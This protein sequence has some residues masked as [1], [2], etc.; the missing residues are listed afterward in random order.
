[1]FGAK[2]SYIPRVLRLLGVLLLVCGTGASLLHMMVAGLLGTRPIRDAVVTALVVVPIGCLVTY[3]YAAILLNICLNRWLR[4]SYLEKTSLGEPDERKAFKMWLR[5][6][7][8]LHAGLF[9]IRGIRISD[10]L[11]RVEHSD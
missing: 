11:E 8:P 1:M 4:T 2:P 6:L 10:V 5:L 9:A 7:Y 3:L